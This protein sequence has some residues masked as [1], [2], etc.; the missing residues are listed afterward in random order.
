MRSRTPRQATPRPP[1][2]LSARLTLC[3]AC[4]LS[5]AGA[6]TGC[7]SEP[8]L[9]YPEPPLDFGTPAA[10]LT[11]RL[12]PEP[13]VEPADMMVMPDMTPDG[14]VPDVA[15]QLRSLGVDWVGEVTP[16]LTPGEARVV[17]SFEWVSGALNVTSGN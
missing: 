2:A 14:E 4:A 1:T 12:E 3:G 13:A 6:L 9:T 11:P 10:P 7:L 17:G 5:L 16:P 8:S 15:P